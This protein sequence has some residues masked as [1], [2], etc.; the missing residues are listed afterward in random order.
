MSLLQF[1][2][3]R[4]WP[5]VV[6]ML[7]F[8]N[9]LARPLRPLWHRGGPSGLWGTLEHKNGDVGGLAWISVASGFIRDHISRFVGRIWD[10]IFVICS[11]CLQTAFLMIWGSEFGC[12]VLQNQ[13]FGESRVAKTILSHIL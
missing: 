3:D 11:V 12:L 1:V 6:A 8:Y 9:S 7:R 10:N 5:H 4:W 2:L 13:A